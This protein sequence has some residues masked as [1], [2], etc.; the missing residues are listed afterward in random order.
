M[1]SLTGCYGSRGSWREF[2]RIGSRTRASGAEQGGHPRGSHPTMK[3]PILLLL[4]TAMWGALEAQAPAAGGDFPQAEISNGSIRAKLYLPDEER[5]YYR[6]ARFDWSGVIASLEYQGHSFFG[7]WFEHYD[8]KLHDAITG[9]VEEFRSAVGPLGYNQAKPGGT[10]VKIGV[11]VLRKPNDSEY[12]FAYPY[13]IVK[14]GKWTVQ[15]GRDR[16]TFTQKLTDDLGY[17]YVYRK[18]VRLAK[19]KPELI[20]EHSLKNTGRRTIETSVYD[21]DFFVIDRQPTGPDFVV[22]FPFTPKANEDLK[23]AAIR[24]K[25]LVYTQELK[26]GETAG[27]YLEGYGKEAGDN[28]IRVE[29]RKTGAGVHEAGNRPVSKFYFWSIRTTVCPEAYIDIK[30]DPGRES[31]W[32]ITYD[33]YTGDMTGKP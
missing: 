8:P 15:R 4:S 5:G 21:H 13:E 29:N 9:P 10:F 17:D 20:L 26:K 2:V 27:A 14:A 18:T 28:D 19:D 7:Q 11:G 3:L 16:V 25:D 32:R 22:K 31:T 6:G 1:P 23:F 33:F 24:G 30:V 12:S